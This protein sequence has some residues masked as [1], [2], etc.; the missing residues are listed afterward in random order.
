MLI[1]QFKPFSLHIKKRLVEFNKPAIM[2]IINV[3][4]DSFYEHSR[5]LRPKQIESRV[6]EMIS[7]GVDIID[8]GAYSSRPGAEHISIHEE[9][10][11][12][13]IG[14]EAIRNIDKLIPISIDT[15]RAEVADKALDLGADIIND[16]SGGQLSNN[17]IFSVVT[18]HKAPYVLMHMR[19][20]PQTMQQYT[21]YQDVITEVTVSL[22]E[23]LQ[24]LHQLGVSDVIVDPGLGFSK[25]IEQNYR[26]LS[27]TSLLRDTLDAPVLIGVSRKSMIT[28]PLNISP[29]QSIEATTCVNTMALSCGAS[30]LRVHDVQQAQ[31]ASTLLRI[32]NQNSLQWT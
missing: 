9:I 22:A 24:Q 17:E 14:V 29:E 13:K 27:A 19:G 15:F 28:R 31:Q 21:D 11:R 32:F 16:I 6:I 2:G 23:R 18:D 30:I 10:E 26:L 3:T 8:L 4:P 1:D 25:T 20:N 7:Q 12:M 5:A